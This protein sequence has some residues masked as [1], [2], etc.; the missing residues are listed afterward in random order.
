MV[1]TLDLQRAEH[2]RTVSLGQLIELLEDVAGREID[3][4]TFSQTFAA[5]IR[6]LEL[7]HGAAARMFKTSRPTISRWES[8][9]SAPHG[10]G[11]PAVFRE[12]RKLAIE[13]RR[14][15]TTGA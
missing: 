5:A 14:R 1:L 10:L 15:H 3:R 12:L 8:G 4:E 11:R 6:M 9:Q 2:E 13:K 7:D